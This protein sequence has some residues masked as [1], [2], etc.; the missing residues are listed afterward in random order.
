MSSLLG[1]SKKNVRKPS[2]HLTPHFEENVK[3]DQWFFCL[4]KHYGTFME[5]WLSGW[6]TGFPILGS[7]VKNYWVAPR[8]SQPFI[9]PRLIKWVLE[10]SKKLL[11]KSKLPP[12]SGSSLETVEPHSQKW[13]TKF[14][15][16]Y[17]LSILF[18]FLF[19]LVIEK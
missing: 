16:F 19:V 1:K 4:W 2:L 13:V 9:C 18:Y 3:L 17:W 14:V 5:Q 8:L 15:F 6:G 11:V 12:E 7:C 10:I